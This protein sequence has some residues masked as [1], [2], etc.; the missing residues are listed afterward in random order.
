VPAAS[1]TGSAAAPD[2][3]AAKIDQ[4]PESRILVVG[5]GEF[6]ADSKGG[7]DRDNL[8]FFQNMVDWLAQDEDLISI[9]SREVTD[10]PLKPV[11]E[12]TK[13]FVKYANMLG[14]PLLVVLLGIAVWQAR[15][16]RKVEI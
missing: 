3:G 4:S 14:S 11:S 1:D 8:L 9:R 16:R 12:P 10:R 13:R 15:R 5:D 2:M 6:F 7:G